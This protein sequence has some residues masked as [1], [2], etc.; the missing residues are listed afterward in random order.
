MKSW[1]EQAGYPLVDIVKNNNTFVVTQ[2]IISNFII[3]T[4]VCEK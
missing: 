3:L 4:V 1:T 2:V